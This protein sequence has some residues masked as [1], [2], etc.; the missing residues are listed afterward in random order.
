MPYPANC[1]NKVKVKKGR[2]ANSVPCI[3]Y[4]H[5]ATRSEYTIF[6]QISILIQSLVIILCIRWLYDDLNIMTLFSG[7]WHA[8]NEV[9]ER[10]GERFTYATLAPKFKA[11]FFDPDEWMSLFKEA[12]AK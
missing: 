6:L 2:R 12:G 8:L 11:E 3:G 9:R 5:P 1:E 4:K 7:E 10:Y